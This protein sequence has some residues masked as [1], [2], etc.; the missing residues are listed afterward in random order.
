MASWNREKEEEE[1]EEEERRALK[2][3]LPHPPRH[4]AFFP[5]NKNEIE[6][7]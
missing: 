4:L 2:T 3:P 7:T 1:V 5:P 6:Q